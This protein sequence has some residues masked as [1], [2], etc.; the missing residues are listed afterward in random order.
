M[1][2]RQA[3][4]TV[5]KEVHEK[6]DEFFENLKAVGI[7]YIGHGVINDLGNHSG[8]FS[9]EKWGQFYIDNKYFFTE[10][11]LDEYKE[12]KM[13]LVSW[14][15]LKDANAVARIRNEQTNIISGM[16]ICKKEKD[17]DT[18][19]N[20]G[21]DQNIDLIEFSFFKRDLLL[22]YFDI[23]NNYHL[24]WRKWKGY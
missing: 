4:R 20:I 2:N 10:P 6:L 17:F 22:A 14:E 1:I 12:G 8:Y 9:N 11:I 15:S 24:Q 13:D 3:S 7:S 18:F 5:P 23:F 19:F 21:F 16:T